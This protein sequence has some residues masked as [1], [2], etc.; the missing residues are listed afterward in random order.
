MRRMTAPPSPTGRVL[1]HYRIEGHLGAGGMGVVYSAYDT[2]LQR[3]V[4]IKVMG[5]RALVDQTARDLLLH[6]AR[7]ASSLNHP[8]IC[9]IHEVGDSDGEA[10][11]VMEQVDG[12]PLSSLVGTTG[13]PPDTV[14]RYGIQIADA[15]DHAHRH[16]IVHRDLKST[17]AV[18]TP[19]GRVK[20]LDFGLAAR[21]LDNEIQEATSSK[22]PFLTESRMIVGTLPYLAPE[23][24]RGDPADARTDTW[25]LGVLL[26]EM[27]SAS[28][29]FRGRTAFEM[30][31]AILRESPA[32]L[33][34]GFPSNL[35][36]V[37]LHCLEK[38]PND[39]YQRASE[40]RSAL[41]AVQF[42]HP[43]PVPPATEQNF[44]F[45]AWFFLLAPLLSI[46]LA[47]GFNWKGSREWLFHGGKKPAAPVSVAAAKPRKSLAV[48][49]FQNA[50]R[51]D[52][53]KWL[54]TALAGMLATELSAGEKLRII[55]AENVTRM[56]RDLALSDTDT[57]ASD[58]LKR[59][60]NFVGSDLILAGS[61]TTLGKLSGGQLRLDVRLQDAATGETLASVAEAGS[62]I[63]LFDL[64]SRV[65][66]DLR[67]RLGVGAMA[68]VDAATVQASY[69]TSPEVARLYAQGLSKLLVFDSLDALP[70]LQKAAAADPKFP[71]AHIALARAWLALGYDARAKDEAKLAFELSG[72]LSREERLLV[73]GQYREMTRDRQVAI[74]IYRTLTGFFPDD[75]EYGL[76]LANA[77]IRGGEPKDA[78]VTI[79]ALKTLPPPQSDDPRISLSEAWAMSVLGD[80]K[81]QL[82]AAEKASNQASVL[83][84]RFVEA[85]AKLSE[86]SAYLNLGEKEK[87]LASWEESRRIWTSAG[88]PGEVAKT[89]INTGIVF[90]QDGNMPEAKRRY[91]EALSIWRTTGNKAGE[92][93]ALAN[94]ANLKDD[95]GDLAGA[96]QMQQDSLAISREIGDTGD[97]ALTLVDLGD[98]QIGLGDPSGAIANDR[99][100][101]KLARQ[102]DDRWTL[103]AALAHISR[104][105]YLSG[106]LPSAKQSVQEALEMSR[107][108]N[109]KPR[110]ARTLA[111]WGEILMAEGDFHQSRRNLEQSLQIRNEIE[112]K[113]NAAA[114]RLQLASLS[115]EEGNPSDAEHVAREVRD[116]YRKEGHPDDEV[117]AA[118]VLLQALLAGKKS[119]EAQKELGN[120]KLLSSKSQNVPNRL[121]LGIINARIQAAA[122]KPEDALQSLAMTMREAVKSGFV[123]SQFEVRL[124]QADIELNSGKPGS[125]RAELTRL[126]KDAGGKGFDLVAQKATVLMT[127]K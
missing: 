88:Y 49:N 84:S 4:A 87:G 41:E 6:E 127:Q 8:N 22:A 99:E 37:I 110:E 54:S 77:Q 23:L 94:L 115:I 27:A 125:G 79:A 92:K 62:E 126:K 12:Q 21:L 106:D 32:P 20:V 71:L 31:S 122:G 45:I 120:T 116:E 59:V 101:I 40:V 65:G 58:T 13:L 104:A 7:T 112:E 64:V 89:L 73:E 117:A 67:N 15:L 121:A 113:S 44:R 119:P 26:Y 75:A 118:V 57:L 123:P 74:E 48:L 93:T 9:T 83:G 90:Y 108:A 95:E 68:P 38:S 66:A 85:S 19:E 63:N 5:N 98:V 53:E 100:A 2:V 124:A 42:S 81:G 25:A 69:P 46:A 52:E 86:G 30:S 103:T 102:L 10:Y 61:Y 47:L 80:S 78:I 50:S 14:V 43:P 39:R 51:R 18:V 17:N 76:R 3:R 114:S 70:L 91:E 34:A 109:D 107:Q 33:P 24:L 56:E 60:R 111:I 105:F 72:N 29:P 35:S 96:R 11:I 97:V 36:G 55:P 16:G 1:G 28:Y 82:R